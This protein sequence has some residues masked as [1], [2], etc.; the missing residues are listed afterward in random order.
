MALSPTAKQLF[1]NLLED[2]KHSKDKH[3]HSIYNKL[4][5][6]LDEIKS[7]PALYSDHK[8]ISLL[9]TSA[10]VLAENNP[11]FSS[12]ISKFI[13]TYHQKHPLTLLIECDEFL[14][15]NDE[16]CSTAEQ[17]SFSP[18]FK[19]LQQALEIRAKR[20]ENPDT[21]AKFSLLP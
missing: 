16:E 7:R 18:F 6:I 20:M 13:I 21:K 8:L 3:H 9:S 12:S 2:Y 5:I 14:E 11:H 15:S 10:H 4:L 17:S 19:E 1:H